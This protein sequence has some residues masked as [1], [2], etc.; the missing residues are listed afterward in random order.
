VT[1][2]TDWEVVRHRVALA[3][4]VLDAEGSPAA[5][6]LVTIV[7]GPQG[8]GLTRTRERSNA[9]PGPDDSM[10]RANWTETEPD[11]TFYF[12]DLPPGTYSLTAIDP[13]SNSQRDVT[14]ELKQE[15]KSPPFADASIQLRVRQEKAEKAK[16]SGRSMGAEKA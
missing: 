14:V 7:S 3:G 4:R 15:K 13:I 9:G 12:L 1:V 6:A 2:W 11:G 8:A 16:S 10:P 5:A